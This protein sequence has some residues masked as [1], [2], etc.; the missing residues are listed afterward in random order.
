MEYKNLT[1]KEKIPVLGLGTWNMFNPEI[2]SYALEKGITHIDTAEFYRTEKIVAEGIKD[3]DR[4]KLFITTKVSPHHL[5]S[6]QILSAAARSLK[7]LKTDYIDLYLIHWPNPL[8]NMKNA[9]KTFD[10]LIDEGLIRYV[11]VSNFSPKQFAEAQSY[12]KNKIVCN[13]V[14]Y[15]LLHRNPEREL[16]D[17]CVKN[18]IILTAYTP[19]ASGQLREGNYKVLDE[20]AEKHS[21]TSIQVALRWLI[22]QPQVITIPKASSKEH[23]DEILGCLG[24]NLDKEDIKN[25][26]ANF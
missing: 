12:T 4:G 23:L 16:L 14:H 5:G 11:G 7:E 8:A 20:I 17:F 22:Q 26:D 1:E 21:K 15:N 19:L 9:M 10:K 25:L 3:F 6:D 2:V 13:Q 18:S 24:W